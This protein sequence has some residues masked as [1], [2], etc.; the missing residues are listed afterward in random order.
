VRGARDRDEL[1]PVRRRA[2][3][4]RVAR[5]AAPRARSA[6]VGTSRIRSP[7]ARAPAT[8]GGRGLWRAPSRRPRATALVA[9]GH[10]RA[11][12][13]SALPRYER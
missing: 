5:R 4:A 11:R 13:T 7:V 12:S 2:R 9:G 1:D 10:D 3:Q 8:V 6:I